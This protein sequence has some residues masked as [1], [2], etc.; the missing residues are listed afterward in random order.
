MEDSPRHLSQRFSDTSSADVVVVARGNNQFAL[1]LYAELRER[2]GNLFFSPSSLSVTLAGLLA[3]ARGRTASQ[4]AE[5]LHLTLDHKSLHAC[6]AEWTSE[7]MLSA[8]RHGNVL[9]VAN[10]LWAQNGC[11]FL[12]EFVDLLIENYGCELEQVDFRAP[13]QAAS[14]INDWVARQTEQKITEIIS[15]EDIGPLMHL[16][17]ANAFYFKGKWDSPFKRHLTHDA[18]FTLEEGSS[19]GRT[20][21]VSL[22][23][24]EGS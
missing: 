1:D 22:M 17:L 6:F 5:T 18:P 10:A 3:G 15:P 19:P 21:Q 8:G 9:R 20:V 4:L 13:Q 11:A 16:M 23:T 24:Q 12:R 7:L 2:E 14:Q